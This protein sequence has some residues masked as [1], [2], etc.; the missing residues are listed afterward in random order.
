MEKTMKKNL[1]FCISFIVSCSAFA[2]QLP[3]GKNLDELISLPLNQFEMELKNNHALLNQ[4]DD[5][6][7]SLLVKAIEQEKIAHIK[8]LLTTGANP[9][10]KDKNNECAVHAIGKVGNLEIARLIIR[11]HA[12]DPNWK[13]INALGAGQNP[14]SY[15]NQ[16]KHYGCATFLWNYNRNKDK[17]PLFQAL[18]YGDL[19]TLDSLLDTESKVN[20]EVSAD[21]NVSCLPLAWA[22][23]L[24]DESL[25]DYLL[26]KGA[27]IY[28]KDCG[29]SPWQCAA[30]SP[31]IK[32]L[33]QKYDN[34]MQIRDEFFKAII[35]E[36]V[37]IIKHHLNKN[38]AKLIPMLRFE[39]NSPLQIAI[40]AGKV[41][42]LDILW[43]RLPKS[44]FTTQQHQAPLLFLACTQN[45]KEIIQY[46]GNLNGLTGINP[47]FDYL[48]EYWPFRYY[49]SDDIKQEIFALFNKYEKGFS[50]NNPQEY[51]T[52][53]ARYRR[54][55]LIN[56]ALELGANVN[57]YGLKKG[58]TA[59][60]WA[61]IKGDPN[62]IAYLLNR[63]A[64]PNIT[65][66]E[67]K[68]SCFRLMLRMHETSLKKKGEQLSTSA[69][70]PC[71]F[72][73]ICSGANPKI[74]DIYGD[75]IFD[76][77]KCQKMT[78]VEKDLI[79]E[80]LCLDSTSKK[81]CRVILTKIKEFQETEHK[82]AL[83]AGDERKATAIKS[84]FVAE[85]NQYM[86]MLIGKS[87]NDAFKD[88]YEKYID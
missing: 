49:I 2:M 28:L 21:F 32:K 22:V 72:L 20:E 15:A 37:G 38:G 62:A 47:K 33:M 31:R 51:I 78:A 10:I 36:D 61:C 30:H 68:R 63:G 41:K 26:K 43:K 88:I 42:S 17:N 57:G 25:V 85:N 70:L 7:K 69:L 87:K 14:C 16:Y 29:I 56:K 84:C 83:N 5:Q 71:Y 3:R 64:N 40:I 80:I 77:I 39:Q 76:W 58:L 23:Y 81:Q 6:G 46:L 54:I 19:H 8:T 11:K 59:L 13:E 53:A 60:H 35:E 67:K 74:K 82:N 12:E 66:G 86:S 65:D 9:W 75:D 48:A 55:E 50:E 73:L 1:L 27:K 45:K 18:M 44:L 52:H 79:V 4:R 24:E 34:S